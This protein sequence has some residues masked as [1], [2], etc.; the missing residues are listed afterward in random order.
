[1][2]A[3]KVA[4]DLYKSRDWAC[5]WLKRYYI[6]G[7]DGLKNRHKSDRPPTVELFEGVSYM[8]KKELKENNYGWSTKQVKELI[9]NE[10][11]IK[12]HYTHLY[13]PHPL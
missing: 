7:I 4:R 10:S 12:Y 6:D 9:V 1:M 8:I 2:I 5:E 13:I 3:V 11:E